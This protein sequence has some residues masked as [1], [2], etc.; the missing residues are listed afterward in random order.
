MSLQCLKP[1]W[2][3]QP[4]A[5]NKI[6]KLNDHPFN[7]NGIE[8]YLT[9]CMKKVNK[10]RTHCR[11]TTFGPIKIRSSASKMIIDTIKSNLIVRI[12]LLLFCFNC[13]SA[14]WSTEFRIEYFTNKQ[15]KRHPP[16]KLLACFCSFFLH[17][18]MFK[19]I[20]AHKIWWSSIF[21]ELRSFLRLWL[22]FGV[23]KGH[24]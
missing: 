5:N 23:F 18:F 21:K 1:T 17:V 6:Y 8:F 15:A 12:M 11:S 14:K 9:S 3:L 2:S 4:S 22:E 20:V 19:D 7:A 10:S 24:F 16:A 13:A